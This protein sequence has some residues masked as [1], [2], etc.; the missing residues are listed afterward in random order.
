MFSCRF[1]E[2]NFTHILQG[3]FTGTGAIIWLFQSRWSNP[4]GYEQIN[5]V[6]PQ[7]P[8]IITEK[9]HNEAQQIFSIFLRIYCAEL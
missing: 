5:H 3:H 8:M 6:N 2:V 7:E 4:E 9:K 1:I